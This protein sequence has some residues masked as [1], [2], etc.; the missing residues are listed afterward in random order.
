MAR[1]HREVRAA[2]Q[3]CHPNIVT[4]YDADEADGVHFLVMEYVEGT[5][6]DWLVKERGP[7]PVAQVIDYLLQAACACSTP[8]TRGS[9]IATSSPAISSWTGRTR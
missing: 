3:L 8:T 4:A 9:F 2:A 7:L 5:D 1:F 6:L